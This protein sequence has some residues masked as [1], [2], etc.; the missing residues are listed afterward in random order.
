MRPPIRR[1]AALLTLVL[2]SLFFGCGGGGS[3]AAT[4]SVRLSPGS[5][6]AVD[7]A[8][9]LTITAT[10]ANDA[11]SAGVT[12]SVSGGGALSSRQP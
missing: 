1:I 2:V 6:Q 9:D 8:Q 4:T 3:S 12:W 10:V 7:Q 5:A 11:A